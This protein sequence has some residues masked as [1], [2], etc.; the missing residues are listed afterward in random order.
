M[1]DRLSK[2]GHFLPLKHPYS[3]QSVAHL[4]AKEIVRLHGIPKDIVSDRDT[5]FC[6]QFWQHIFQ[7]QGVALHMSTAYHPQSDGQSEV[8]NRCLETYLRCFCSQQPHLWADW[9]CWAEYHYNTSYHSTIRMTPYEAVYGRP[10]L[11]LLS[12]IPGLADDPEVD[13]QLRSRH[14]ILQTLQHN[15]TT[16]QQRMARNANKHRIDVEYTIGD[17]VYL[18]L[19]PYRQDSLVRRPSHKLSA[20]YFGPYQIIGRCGRVA[21]K[22]QLPPE[23]KIHHTFHVSQLKRRHGDNPVQQ[24][25]TPESLCVDDR[26]PRAIL[27]RRLVQRNNQAVSQILLAWHNSPDSEATWLD[28][29]AFKQ[30]YPNC[31]LEDEVGSHVGE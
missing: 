30:L 7:L 16:A 25:P 4:F 27:Q 6:S 11:S 8:L 24:L 17:W 10:P 20:R 28:Y 5:V 1:V 26:Q 29:T 23:A 3:A 12:Y 13:T 9:L 21:Y 2:Y 14:I 18:K 19:Q 22:L 15:M 31:N